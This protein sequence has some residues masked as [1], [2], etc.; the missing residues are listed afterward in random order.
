[1]KQKPARKNAHKERIFAL[2]QN[3]TDFEYQKSGQDKSEN[4]MRELC[5][6]QESVYK[7]GLRKKDSHVA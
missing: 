6:E 7:T 3:K 5:G 4:K 2:H 1:M